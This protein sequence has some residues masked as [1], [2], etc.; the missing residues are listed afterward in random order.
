MHASIASRP[1]APRPASGA[2]GNARLW[3]R[4]YGSQAPE[5]FGSAAEAWFWTMAALRARRDGA[6]PQG[7]RLLRPCAPDDVVKCLD[8]LY[9]RRRIDLAHARVL[10]MWGELGRAPNPAHP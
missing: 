9:R 1:I 5:P 6:Q 7:T 4:A 3:D 8:G 2:A 10:R